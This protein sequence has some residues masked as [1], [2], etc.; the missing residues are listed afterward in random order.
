VTSTAGWIRRLGAR[1][2]QWLH[3]LIYLSGIAAVI[4]Y[5]WLV[6]S[7][8]RLPAL[9]GAILAVL[10]ASRLFSLRKKQTKNTTTLKLLNIE[11]QTRDTV[12]MRFLLPGNVRLNAKPGQ[13][14]T[15][16]WMVQGKKLPRSYSISSSPLRSAF[17]EITVKE[18][19]VVSTFLN[20]EALE[21]LT[22]EAHGPFGQ[23]Y[24]DET[25]H[26]SIVL[27]AGGSG[28][29]PIISMLRY[30]AEVSPDTGITLF[31]AIR[32][33]HD[34]I[35]EHELE[36]LRELLPKF[37]CVTIASRASKHWR[38][39]HGHLNRTLIEQH[40][41][42]IDRQTFFLCGPAGFMR[43]AKHVLL[44]LNVGN[45]QI[46]QERFTIDSPASTSLAPATC[47]V[48]FAKSGQTYEGSSADTLLIIAERHGIDVPFS[49]RVG[50][51]GTCATRVLT[52]DV[53]MDV[54]EGLEPALRAQGYR[55]LC[56]GRARG[57]V[58]LEA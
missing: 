16:D 18:Q 7:D 14:L 41:G 37:R 40:V 3:R 47:T 20:R 10:L 56:V 46:L 43:T 48:E 30:I 45:E 58:T 15:F 57:S 49:C 53:E 55:L 2:W 35:F 13:F 19:G 50:Q 4:H 42:Q 8:I 11:R 17:V 51:C 54:D 33:E 12:T 34:L 32:S 36:S 29:T 38:G 23:F 39:L 52:G 44:S 21:G 1:R 25:R 22:V 26:R 28:I 6:K 27:F 24:F 9:Y 5:Y 31:Y